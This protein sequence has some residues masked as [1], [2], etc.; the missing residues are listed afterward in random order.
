[1]LLIA[2]GGSNG[3]LP[4]LILPTPTLSSSTI[5]VRRSSMLCLSLISEWV[6]GPGASG[7]RPSWAHKATSDSGLD[8]A[9]ILGS[10]YTSWVDT[11]Y[12]T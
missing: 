12:L 5:A 7:T 4:R 9:S 2:Q 1:M 8:I 11:S 3:P 6:I 10:N